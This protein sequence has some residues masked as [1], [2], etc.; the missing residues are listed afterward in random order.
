VPRD[1]ILGTMNHSYIPKRARRR[2]VL[3]RRVRSNLIMREHYIGPRSRVIKIRSS[4]ILIHVRREWVVHYVKQ[5][6][7][8]ER[9]KYKKSL[10]ADRY[11][12][13]PNNRLSTP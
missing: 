7:K 12:L 4:C 6:R 10:Y 5:N 8:E 11:I 13:D 2:S 1:N 3:I 9:G